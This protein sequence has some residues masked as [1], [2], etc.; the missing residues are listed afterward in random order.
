VAQMVPGGL[1]YQIFMTF[2]TWM[3]WGRQA[4]TPVAFTPRNVRGTYFNQGLSRLQG[5]GAMG[6]KYDN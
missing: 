1:D 6:R 2:G 3:W 4:P 5:H